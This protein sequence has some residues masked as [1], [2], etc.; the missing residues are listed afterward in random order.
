MIM[1]TSF[2]ILASTFVLISLASTACAQ[3]GGSTGTGATGG[4]G[5]T[6]GASSTGQSSTGGSATGQSGASNLQS[7]SG[8]NSFAGVVPGESTA[9]SSNA[10]ESFIGS[11][12][13]TGFIGGA[14]QAGNQQNTNRQ[15]QA[16]QNNQS[17]QSTSQQS[18]TAREVR[19]TL[20]VSFAFPSATQMQMNGSLVN[21][22]IASLRR[23]SP[24][25]PELAGI[26]VALNSNGIAVL[27]GSAPTVETRRLAANLIR[28][29][30]GIRKVEN[31]IVVQAN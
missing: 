9:T 8:N 14:S 12:A 10:S 25:R 6:T 5:S 22:N 4:T 7:L 18:G 17:Q 2:R 11:S 15:F 30:P 3:F 29:Q 16:L 27:S 21:P 24:I 20:R 1:T 23:F 31:Q 19:T 28:L 13:T 26:E